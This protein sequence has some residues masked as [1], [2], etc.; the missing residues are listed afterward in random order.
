MM[1]RKLGGLEGWVI[2]RAVVKAGAAAGGMALAVWLW[3]GQAGSLP[4]V[5]TALGGVALGGVVFAGLLTL[6]R[7]PEVH[8]GISLVRSRLGLS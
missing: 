7:V 6:L 5:V 3:L 4:T 8:Q 1:R 2:L